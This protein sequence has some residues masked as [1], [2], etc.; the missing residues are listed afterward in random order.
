MSNP[1][2]QNQKRNLQPTI[3]TSAYSASPSQLTLS[4]DGLPAQLLGQNPYQ[5]NFAYG[6]DPSAAFAYPPQPQ[7]RPHPSQQ[8]VKPDYQHLQQLQQ[9]HQLPQNPQLPSPTN[10]RKRRAS[11]IHDSPLPGS[12]GSNA[13]FGHPQQQGLMAAPRDVGDLS[14]LQG[15][16]NPSAPKKGRTNTPWTPA[17]EQRLKALRD[18]G[19][20]WSEIAK[21]FPARTEGSV[22][23]HWYKVRIALAPR[24]M[25][26]TMLSGDDGFDMHYADFA[27]DE[28][29][30]FSAAL[31][32]AIK[33]YENNKWK[34]IG[35]KV[36]K[37]AKA[38]EQFAKE[39]GWKI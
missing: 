9:T 11:D 20:S 17:E 16:P 18:A 35:Q 19:S 28:V 39:Q 22:K 24:Q 1:S 38:C 13:A 29:S 5:Q 21:T 3:P 36:G 25:I 12:S 33:D 26:L 32:Q 31:L 2:Q 34:V 27:E 14:G 4:S 10:S 6:H 23:K 7:Y 30:N 8:Q 37:P 15:L